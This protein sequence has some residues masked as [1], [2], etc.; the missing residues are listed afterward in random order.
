MERLPRILL[1]ICLFIL[2]I[3]YSLC[4]TL[5]LK[6]I[7]ID[8]N[9][10]SLKTQTMYL[11]GIDISFMIIIFLLYRKDILNNLSN[12]FKNFLK[13][14]STGFKCW[15]IGILI[16][17]IS[18]I[19]LSFYIPSGASNE[20]AVQTILKQMPQYMIF[21][22]VIYAPFVEELIFRKS[23]RDIVKNDYLYILV[24]GFAFGL[25]HTLTSSS[26][27]EFLYIIPYGT[28]GCCFAYSYVKTKNIF[29]PITFHMIHNA[30]VVIISLSKFMGA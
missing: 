29:V 1:T 15:M 4:V 2:E 16:M 9:A 5:G 26:S 8:I 28:L 21:S 17:I 3:I 20:Q 7:G 6:Y 13:C 14:F 18:N 23:I 11:I 22:A 27:L 10:M 30:I 12:Y 19:V 25:A 24:S